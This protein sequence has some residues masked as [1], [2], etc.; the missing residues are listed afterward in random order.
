MVLATAMEVAPGKLK[1]TIKRSDTKNYVFRGK[2]ITL[3]KERT[4]HM[5]FDTELMRVAG[6]WKGPY[7]GGMSDKNMGPTVEGTML[8]QSKP[9]CRAG[10]GRASGR[11]R[12]TAARGRCRRLG[13]ISRPVCVRRS[14]RSQ[15][16]GWRR[17]SPRFD[18]GCR[19]EWRAVLGS[20]LSFRPDESSAGIACFRRAK[21]LRMARS[22]GKRRG[23][24][25]EG[26]ERGNPDEILRFPPKEKPRVLADNESSFTTIP[27]SN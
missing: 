12:A 22:T 13:S 9:G 26:N 8:M 5:C 3:N 16:H 10:L 2:W 20:R 18:F 27:R 24:I 23:D 14:R 1:D 25:G 11:I 15:L 21:R 4:I 17:R 19:M 7:P 6:V